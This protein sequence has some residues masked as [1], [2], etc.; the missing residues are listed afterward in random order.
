MI[1]G[2]ELTE[3]TTKNAVEILNLAKEYKL[4]VWYAN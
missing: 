1:G 2:V 3:L 4:G